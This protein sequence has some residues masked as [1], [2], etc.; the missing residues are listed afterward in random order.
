MNEIVNMNLLRKDK[1]LPEVHLKKLEFTYSTCGTFSKT[2]AEYK[3]LKKQ[4]I[5]DIFLKNN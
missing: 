4:K 3:N 5:Q 2:R 1:V